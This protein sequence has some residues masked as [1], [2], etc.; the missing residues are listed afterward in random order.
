VVAGGIAQSQSKEVEI[1]ENYLTITQLERV[2]A[3]RIK[4]DT[5]TKKIVVVSF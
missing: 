4:I 3:G 2:M 1:S 5:R